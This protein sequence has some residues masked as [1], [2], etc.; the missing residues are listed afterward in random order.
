MCGRGVTG[1]AARF[2]PYAV[3]PVSLVQGGT[4]CLEM[5]PDEA[6]ILLFTP[7]S[8]FVIA[9]SVNDGFIRTFSPMVPPP[10]P[11]AGLGMFA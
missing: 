10:L 1:Y 6:A 3:E 11:G 2:K 9:G 4:S 7:L 8:S 5:V